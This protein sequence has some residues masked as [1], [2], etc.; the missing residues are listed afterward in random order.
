MGDSRAIDL[1]QQVDVGCRSQ[2]LYHDFPRRPPLLSLLTSLCF[3][4]AVESLS[5]SLPGLRS[6]GFYLDCNPKKTILFRFR[7]GL[8]NLY[9]GYNLINSMINSCNFFSREKN[10]ILCLVV[11]CWQLAEVSNENFIIKCYTNI[12]DRFEI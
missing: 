7:N 3:K 2:P 1:L 8:T 4:T 11:F 12:L 5:L 6:S 10:C 9:T